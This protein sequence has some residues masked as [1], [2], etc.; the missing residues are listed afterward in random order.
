[1]FSQLPSA[2]AIASR[3]AGGADCAA[4]HTWW[5]M[6]GARMKPTMT[7]AGASTMPTKP[8]PHVQ[9]APARRH[10]PALR[11]QQ[12]QE[13]P[14]QHRMDVQHQRERRPRPGMHQPTFSSESG[15]NPAS[16]MAMNQAAMTRRSSGRSR[17]PAASRTI[18]PA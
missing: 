2:T 4:P 8:E 10:Q 17:A 5:Y 16:T 15:M 11:Q 9:S 3:I 18:G 6:V 14:H 12:Q 1:M 7:S 13:R